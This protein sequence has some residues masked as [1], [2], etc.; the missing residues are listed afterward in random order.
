MYSPQYTSKICST[1]HSFQN[2]TSMARI[3]KADIL[4]LTV[5]HLTNLEHQQR[6]VTLATEVD[7]YKKGFKD[8]ARETI[9]YL[10]TTRSLDTDTLHQLNNHLQSSYIEKT[11]KTPNASYGPA[12]VGSAHISTRQDVPPHSFYVSNQSTYYSVPEQ[13]V[14][15]PTGRSDYCSSE[16]Y[17]NHPDYYSRLNDSVDTSLNSSCN[18]SLDSSTNITPEKVVRYQDAADDVW[19]PW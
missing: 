2:S 10:S 3:D 13:S 16:P 7:G 14:V 8:C 11:R 1:F 18:M 9:R 4:E 17:Y 19:R 15:L 5:S 12:D 6:S